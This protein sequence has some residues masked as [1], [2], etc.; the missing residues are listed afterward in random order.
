[1]I[2][3][4]LR[5]CLKIGRDRSP[6][7]SGEWMANG[8][9]HGTL[10]DRVMGRHAL[11]ILAD[12][13]EVG[14]CPR[15]W[16][17]QTLSCTMIRIHSLKRVSVVAR[18]IGGL[19][20]L[21]SCS[22]ASTGE[23]RVQASDPVTGGGSMAMAALRS[24]AVAAVRQPVTTS[25]LGIA[26]LWHRPRELVSANLPGDLTAQPPLAEAPGTAEFET[27]LDERRFPLAEAGSLDWLV[28]GPGFFPELS[29]QIAAARHSINIQVF[30]YDND[31]IG[32][33][34]ANLLKRRSQE[35]PVHVLFDDLGTAFAHTAAPAALGP[36]GF[37]PPPDMHDFLRADS[38]V[39]VRRTLNPWFTADHTKLLVFD[40]HTAILG[41][42]NIGREYF[43]EWH[44]LMVRV[45]G[46][47]VAKL[48][49]EFSRA[50][51]K[52]GPWGDF[53]LFRKP[54]IFQH[55]Q[56]VVGG[57]PLRILRTDPAEGR[58][59]ILESSLLAIRG[60]RKRVWVEN[61]YVAHDD[62]VAA[63][64]AAAR[65]G[66]D[67]RLIIPGRGDST[68]MDAANLAAANGLIQAGVKV[69]RYPKM[70]HL[71]AMICDDWASVGSANLDT[72]SM[73]INRELNLA[74]SNH[75]AVE[76]LAKR[77]FLPDFTKS[78]RV[79][80][81]ETEGVGNELAETIADQL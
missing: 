76:K 60:A 23:R 50:W 51:R 5:A 65:R 49:R 27:M 31:D 38:Q 48:A 29:R 67:V 40:Q 54:A 57:I 71:K 44:D 3:P 12:R 61:P 72:L 52:A 46:P 66:V 79:R 58:H 13:P 42:M 9:K 6:Q 32:V 7:R 26:M 8:T 2:V 73:R 70:T 69:Y 21:A 41:G 75:E 59:E 37:V 30:I 80:L 24:T 18:L 64:A 14:P 15:A 74:F 43:S 10:E 16:I 56:A 53:A 45:E 78:R 35:I 22:V 25:R 81:A 36:R 1:M 19:A 17:R 33:R 4:S 47:I 34:Y 68:I 55:P 11:A 62:L 63:M 39:Q 28:D 20:L 77:V